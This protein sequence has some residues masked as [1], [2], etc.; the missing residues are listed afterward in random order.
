MKFRTGVTGALEVH[1]RHYPGDDN[2]STVTISCG[3]SRY[4]LLFE[5][6]GSEVEGACLLGG[7]HARVPCTY[8]GFSRGRVGDRRGL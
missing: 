8:G 3:V 2:V 7:L 5:H 6:A 1:S 4:G